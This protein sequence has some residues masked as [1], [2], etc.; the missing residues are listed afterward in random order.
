MAADTVFIGIDP[1]AGGRLH[2]IAM[3]DSRL[4][5]VKLE[6]VAFKPLITLVETYPLAVCGVDAPISPGKGLMTDPGY[7][8]R[9][10]LDPRSS[11]YSNYRV[12]EYE[13][14]KRKINLYNTPQNAAEA[15]R[16]IQEG[17]RIY[18]ALRKI[19]F[20]EY[21]RPG[22]RR[23]FETFPHGG[24]MAIIKRKPYSK[25]T[26][27][28]LLQR[29]MILFEEGLSVPD[30]MSTL[31]E[32]T[33]HK[34][35]VGD[36]SRSGLYDHDQLDALMAAYTAYLVYTQPNEVCAVGDLAEGQIVLPV[37]SLLDRY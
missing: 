21:P 29:Q 19:G 26:V 36:L 32:W 23:M 12:C 16:W 2:A 22:G 10:G 27:E 37:P 30:P 25:S 11:S 18:E 8:Q 3:L 14:R 7:R 34:V 35:L 31:E 6:K 9:L 4:R 28:G 15:P 20:V 33:R 1:T 5:V 17:W 24:F 13:L